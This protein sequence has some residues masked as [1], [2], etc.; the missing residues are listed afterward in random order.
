MPTLY[1]VIIF[2]I[3]LIFASLRVVKQYERSVIFFLGKFTGIRGPGLI[4]LIPIFERMAKVML[5]TVTMNIPSQKI[6]TKDNVSIDIAAVAYYHIVDPEKA[7]IGV[8]NVY[9]AV[10]QISQTTVRNVVGQFMLDQLLSQTGEINNQIKN[11]I[12]AHTEPWGA[13]VTA[14]EIK[15]IVLPDNM[16]RA[17]AKEA[18]AERE[19]RAKIVAAQGEFQAA[20]KLGEAAD[21]IMSHPIALQ[22][23]TLQTLAEISTEKNS[24][25]IFP[26]QFMNNIR[27]VLDTINADAISMTKNP[28]KIIK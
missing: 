3:V 12:D 9:E 11:V 7:V 19:R 8:E 26:A 23:R 5:R 17:M 2:L 22:L 25:I 6:I 16:Q 10:N 27:E 20:V 28:P 14:V 24:T 15:D 18:E 21:I 1:Y 13:Q 4:I